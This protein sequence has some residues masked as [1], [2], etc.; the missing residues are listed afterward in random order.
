[1][2]EGSQT[3]WLQS[4]P[5][6]LLPGRKYLASGKKVPYKSA[7]REHS[8]QAETEEKRHPKTAFL[9]KIAAAATF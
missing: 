2:P 1:M 7:V 4:Y 6:A 8:D 9:L 5:A 3:L